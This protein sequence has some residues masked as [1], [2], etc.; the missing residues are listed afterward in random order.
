MRGNRQGHDQSEA[1]L[2]PIPAHAG[3]PCYVG[4]QVL[5]CEGLSPRMRG[6]QIGRL[7][8]W[9]GVRPIPAH[10]GQPGRARGAD[11]PRRAYPRAC[12]ATTLPE[13]RAMRSQGL[14][15]RMRGNQ[16]RRHL[17]LRRQG[18]I[19]AHAGQPSAAA[20][21]TAVAWAY[22]RA[23]G[24]TWRWAMLGFGSS[25]LSPRMRGNRHDRGP[26]RR[27]RGPIP[28]H[29]GQ[30]AAKS[31]VSWHLRA[32][33]RACGATQIRPV[34]PSNCPGLSPRM[35]GNRFPLDDPELLWGP[36]PAHAGQP[37]SRPL[38]H[39]A[40]RAYPRACGA[41]YAPAVQGLANQGL[42]PR[43]RGN[44]LTGA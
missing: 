19:P 10:A 32:Y 7:G 18:P 23:C 1:G 12:G 43:M 22:P 44:P 21:T 2:R 39:R 6:N 15:P 38:S 11:A 8:A 16:P 27:S 30:P 41:T 17:R 40:H 33:P 13:G 37:W 5:L 4:L 14:S 36:I 20:R 28:A 31:R 35:R 24:A 3:Q 29:A 26:A 42:S 9:E 34:A 25:G